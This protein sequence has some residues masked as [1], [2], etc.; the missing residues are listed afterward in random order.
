M[1]AL[2]AVAL[3]IVTQNPVALRAAPKQAALQQATL[4]QG[5]VL[6]V[7]GSRGDYL[8]VYDHRLERGGYV[9]ATQVREIGLTP[10]AAPALLAVVR[11]LRETP[12][13]EALGISYGAAFLKAAPASDITPEIFDALGGMAERLAARASKPGT[14]K[15]A[16]DSLAASLDIAAQ[17]GIRM[18]TLERDG[19]MLFCYDGDL[20]KRVLEMP[21]ADAPQRARA[22]LA[23]T[24]HDCV[25][26]ALGPTDRRQLD[27][28]RAEV[29]GRVPGV[30]LD[31]VMLNRIHARQAGVLA[32]VAY[33]QA[34]SGAADGAAIAA[35]L[36]SRAIAELATVK[37]SALDGE[38]V[39]AYADAAI[40]VGASRPAATLGTRPAGKLV[41]QTT[42]GSAGQT[43]VALYPAQAVLDTPLAHRCTY[44]M[45]WTSSAN[46]NVTGTALALAV[47]PLV[48]WRELW[49]FHQTGS[50][51][52]IDVL[53]PGTD[54]PELGYVECAG[55]TP[56][57]RLLVAREVLSGGHY[58]RRF[59]VLDPATLRVRQ[60]ASTPELLSS[61]VRWQDPAW[62]RTTV[63]VR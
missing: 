1:S 51:W 20:Y 56:D 39:D 35:Q 42:A 22:A 41:L 2:A 7:R 43:C 31:A 62:R 50:G 49:I 30:G 45:V 61:F 52:S 17:S 57:S 55:W 47:Q 8:S 9:R 32:E 3:A 28:W 27:L 24:R 53:P 58:R 10:E 21:A 29:L 60:Q 46:A 13:A 34:R 48:G 14:G 11:F 6:E 54:D 16:A 44:G 23:L 26:P 40:R 36:E 4:W 25:D 33:W 59:E 63:A 12:G 15:S 18:S 38:D 19:Q 5:E 37:K